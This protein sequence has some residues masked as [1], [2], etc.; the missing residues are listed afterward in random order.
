MLE[1][2]YDNCSYAVEPGRL[3]LVEYRPDPL[4]NNDLFLQSAMVLYLRYIS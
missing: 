2:G 1:S 4:T 3:S